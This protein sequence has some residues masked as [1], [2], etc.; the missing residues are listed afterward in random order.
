MPI[1]IDRGESKKL[2]IKVP[3]DVS[4]DQCRIYISQRKNTVLKY[5]TDATDQGNGF[6]A[7]D[8][9]V[10]NAGEDKTAF[11][12]NM[13]ASESTLLTFGLWDVA[14]YT[15][16]AEAGFTEDYKRIG[17]SKEAINVSE[18]LDVSEL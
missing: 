11:T 1:E 12:L 3:G 2:T 9:G 14:F 6:I 4:A 13:E 18:P 7:I 10:Y 8:A 15:A 16:K 5:S 17:D